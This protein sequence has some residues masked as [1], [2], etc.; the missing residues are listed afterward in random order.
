MLD[1]EDQ[2]NELPRPREVDPKV[3][4][5]VGLG[6]HAGDER[7]P[8]PAA[9][10]C[11]EFVEDLTGA[12]L[13]PRPAAGGGRPPAADLWYLV[14]R[15]ELGETHTVKGTTDGIRKALKDGLLGDASNVRACRTKTGQFLV[16]TSTRSSATW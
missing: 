12:T 1:A 2:R 13:R 14:Y 16:L 8:G 6:D 10:H 5:R 7:G 11:K 3:S 15:D 4:E 9:G